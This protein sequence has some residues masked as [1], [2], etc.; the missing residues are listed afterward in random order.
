M[1]RCPRAHSIYPFEELAKHYEHEAHDY[2]RAEELVVQALRLLPGDVCTHTTRRD[3]EKR[4]HRIRDKLRS[5]RE[6]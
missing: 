6:T 1:V 4:L 5:V 2:A 3:L